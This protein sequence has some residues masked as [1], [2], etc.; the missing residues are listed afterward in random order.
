MDMITSSG[1]SG[2]ELDIGE[3]L[4]RLLQKQSFEKLSVKDICEEA[5]INRSTFYNYFDD[6]HQLLDAV[7]I[8][9]TEVYID[10]FQHFVDTIKKKDPGLK[11][12]QY[13]LHE[14]IL[15]YYLETVREY[16]GVFQTFAMRQGTFYS[17]EQFEYMVND[18]VLPMLRKHGME[19]ARMAEYM[20]SFYFGAMHSM[21]ATWIQHNCEDAIP[22]MVRMIQTCMNIPSEYFQ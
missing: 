15:T 9:S 20:T 16:R 6:K 3:A 8:A 14:E 11:P 22:Y 10:G 18:I 5:G 4:V 13:L 17:E 1:Y 12:E 7:M 19:D 2:I 21:V